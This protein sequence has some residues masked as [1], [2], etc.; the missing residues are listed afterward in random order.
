MQLLDCQGG[1]K[2]HLSFESLEPAILLQ[3]VGKQI[4]FAKP[5][6][7]VSHQPLQGLPESQVGLDKSFGH[8]GGVDAS[9]NYLL[10]VLDPA[11]LLPIHDGH[12]FPVIGGGGLVVLLGQGD[13]VLAGGVGGAQFQGLGK[14]GQALVESF[15]PVKAQ[16]LVV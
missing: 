14:G 7:R 11:S 1:V 4:V 15:L 9:V 6:S 12:G 8:R 10:V 3:L 5:R 13:V 2:F 16:G